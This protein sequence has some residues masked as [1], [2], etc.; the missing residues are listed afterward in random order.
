MEMASTG[1]DTV[2][3]VSAHARPMWNKASRPLCN[4][5]YSIQA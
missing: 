5:F 1:T 2:P 4:Q 3:I